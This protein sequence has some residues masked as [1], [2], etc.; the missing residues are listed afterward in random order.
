M[1]TYYMSEGQFIFT[2]TERSDNVYGTNQE[3]IINGG[4]GD[5]ILRGARGKDDVWAQHGD[6]TVYGGAGNDKLYGETGADFLRGGTGNDV[7]DGGLGADR[8]EGGAGADRFQFNSYDQ[9][10]N[11]GLAEIKGDIVI[12]FEPG[13]DKL[14][15][16]LDANATKD[17][18]QKAVALSDGA[19]WVAGGYKVSF[20][21]KFD[22]TKVTFFDGKEFA[23]VLVDVDVGAY[24]HKEIK[25]TSYDF[26]V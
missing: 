15:F 23:S 18:V 16:A 22:A 26:V 10:V 25:F 1:A 20:D 19:K 8:L 11:R 17:G 24:T 12:D 9:G 2:G 14:W 21:T 5:D 13:K 7:L 6:D 4:G 3:N